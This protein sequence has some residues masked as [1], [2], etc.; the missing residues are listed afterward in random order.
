V[1][2]A[3]AAADELA[4]EGI[5]SEVIDL[6]SLRPLDAEAIAASA[7]KT[8]RLVVVEEGPPTGGYSGDV[9]ATAVELAGP[10]AAR[11]VTMPDLPIPFSPPLE[12]A[13]IPKPAAVVEAVKAVATRG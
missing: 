3:L 5:E 2:V 10:L 7:A 4:Q 6:R 13:A 12:D 1:H 8:G 9:I 11:R